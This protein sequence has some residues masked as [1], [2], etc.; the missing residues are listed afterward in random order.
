L[1][2]LRRRRN[3]GETKEK[4]RRNEGETK[5]KRRRDEGETKERRRSLPG[6]DKKTPLFSASRIGRKFEITIPLAQIG[7]IFADRIAEKSS[8][9][10]TAG[11]GEL[12]KSCWL[13]LTCRIDRAVFY[14][15]GL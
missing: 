11:I 7:M 3:E 5:E 12:F 8:Y 6:I 14:W 13:I 1:T 9:A 4:R 15:G 10:L 2:K